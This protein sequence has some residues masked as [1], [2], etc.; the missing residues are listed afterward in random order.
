MLTVS[1]F[2]LGVDC[3]SFLLGVDCIRRV[4]TGVAGVEGGQDGG[5]NF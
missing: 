4:Q 3:I 5:L 2:L 1:V